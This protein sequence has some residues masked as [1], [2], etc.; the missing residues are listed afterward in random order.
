MAA[1]KNYLDALRFY[2]EQWTTDQIE[3]A[4]QDEIKALNDPCLSCI[5]RE[6]AQTAITIYEQVL[7]EK[8]SSINVA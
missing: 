8:N 5:A 4:I 2:A 7:L 1:P 3:E 6:S